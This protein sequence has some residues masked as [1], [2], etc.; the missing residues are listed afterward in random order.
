MVEYAAPT[1]AEGRLPPAGAMLTPGLTVT[2]YDPLPVLRAESV[3]LTVKLMADAAAVGV[4]D[5]MP[6]AGAMLSQ[7]GRPVADQV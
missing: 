1:K 4:Q 7:E 6:V 5:T 2:E 3:T